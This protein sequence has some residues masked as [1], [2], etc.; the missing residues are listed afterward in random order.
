MTLWNY[1][2]G[3]YPFTQCR[4]LDHLKIYMYIKLWWNQSCNK[5]LRHLQKLSQAVINTGNFTCN[6]CLKRQ[7]ALW[8]GMECFFMIAT[9]AIEKH[10]SIKCILKILLYE[11]LPAKSFHPFYHLRASCVCV[12]KRQY[13]Q[14]CRASRLRLAFNHIDKS[15]FWKISQNLVP[16][17]GT[18]SRN[19]E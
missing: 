8:K 15:D 14:L 16:C 13:R 5:S 6:L 9:K 10:N 3:V 17:D 12:L 7:V 18:R 11:C 4:S 1:L 2:D 19:M